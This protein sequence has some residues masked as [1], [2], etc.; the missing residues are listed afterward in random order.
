MYF[1]FSSA[2]TDSRARR[3]RVSKSKGGPELRI[4]L[5]DCKAVLHQKGPEEASGMQLRFHGSCKERS[6]KKHVVEK[7]AGIIDYDWTRIR[8]V[9][10]PQLRVSLMPR[11]CGS[12]TT[13]S[14]QSTACISAPNLVDWPD[15]VQHDN[16]ETS[17]RLA[18][19]NISTSFSLLR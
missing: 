7:R 18:C 14:S 3:A 2:T 16:V 5:K 1:R 13:F 11:L 15:R 4:R 6:P 10:P 19:R 12:E 8:L 17:G 9:F